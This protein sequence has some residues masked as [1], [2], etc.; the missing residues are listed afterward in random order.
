MLVLV[1]QKLYGRL[2][3]YWQGRGI[4]VFFRSFYPAVEPL[5]PRGH[6]TYTVGYFPG[7]KKSGGGSE[8]KHSPSAGADFRNEYSDTSTYCKRSH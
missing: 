4:S 6:I 8:A 3:Y 1:S 5:K 7:E 2:L